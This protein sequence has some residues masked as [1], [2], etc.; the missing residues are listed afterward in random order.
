MFKT[1][2]TVIKMLYL[3]L[4]NAALDATEA[5]LAV[6]QGCRFYIVGR[7]ESFSYINHST[8]A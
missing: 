1:P 3:V 8:M 2:F 4:E 5:F 6:K 7:Q